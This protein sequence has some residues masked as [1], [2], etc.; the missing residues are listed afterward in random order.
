[1]RIKIPEIFSKRPLYIQLVFTAFAFWLMVV[2]S[3]VFTSRI[4]R[5][6]LLRNVDN[7]LDYVESTINSDLL[8]SSTILDGFSQSIQNLVRRGD[9]AAKLTAYNTDISSYLLLKNHETISPNGPYGYIENSPGGPFFF[10][11]IG[12][13]PPDNWQ[14]TE[15]PWY[16]AAI[17]AG[18]GIA[19]TEPFEDTVTGEMVFAWSRCIF[20][21]D[22]NRIGVVSIDIRAGHIGER[23]A[24]T[25][26]TKGGFGVLVTQDLTVIGHMNPDFVGLKMDDPVIPL[27]FLTDELVRTGKI[28]GAEWVNWRGEMVIG[29]FKTLSNGW[30]LGLLA[31]K[32][33][34]YEP[35]YKMAL[36]LSVL[37]I[38]LAAVL[39][40]VLINVDA[41]KNK[42]DTENKHKSAFLANMS[43]EIRTPMNAII[44]MITIGKSASDIGRKDYCFTKIEDAAN[45]LLGIIC[46]IL[47]MSKIEANKFEFSPVE[48]NLEETLQRAVN[49]INF[50]LDE[51]HQKLSLHID[52][53]I[54][55][56]LMGDDHRI[57]QIITNLLGNAV[58]FTPENGAISLDARLAGE[59]NQ[60]CTLQISVSDTGIGISA[61]QQKKLFQS[62][63][64]A[65]SSTT[66]KYGGTGLGL[67]ISKSI[68]EMMG[69]TIWVESEP[70]KGS[71]F[72]F[73]IQAA[74]G[75]ELI[76]KQQGAETEKD[77]AP[78]IEG[79]FAG[80]HMLLAEDV[81]INREIVQALLEPT[82]LEI[83]CAENGVEAVRKFT[84]APLKYD[85]IFMDI[86]MPE[87]DGYE[88]TRR[89]RA[90]EAGLRSA[91]NKNLGFPKEIPRHLSER[92]KGVPIVA[93]TANVFR[94]DIERCLDAGMNSHIGKPVN[95][96]EVI[97]KLNSYLAISA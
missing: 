96:D 47:D 91:G 72:T 87:M 30:R 80:R 84:E 6:N 49:V 64:Q 66:R 77:Q 52:K 97:G 16:T 39:I 11:G 76:N 57:A 51:K 32:D 63:E 17:E 38:A 23:V 78:E 15:R 86:Q 83:D 60:L 46:D 13:Q 95:F 71:T 79:I 9:G 33:I 42:S 58:K 34:Y 2:L 92:S 8:E 24:H 50:R 53:S 70:G 68:V 73:T 55:R 21:E 61:E 1:M 19:Q 59:E 27:S 69:G 12:W 18:G 65:E 29:F 93:M 94:E 54:P 85:M 82:Q 88:A 5:T 3:C 26:L 90:V 75:T 81:E 41:A 20:D 36:T 74:R 67:A 62:F 37:G 40:I 22:G 45:H 7:I 44:G 35:V 31:P 43:H 48:F 28:T 4:V 25:T 56:A 10:N 89:I 14:P